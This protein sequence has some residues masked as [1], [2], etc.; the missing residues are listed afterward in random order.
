MSRE[1]KEYAKALFELSLSKKEKEERLE[2]LKKTALIM[3]GNIEKFFAHPKISKEKKKEIIK[4]D[5]P[6]GVFRNFLFVLSDNGR[7]D[8]IEDIKIDFE[9]LLLETNKAV[10]AKVFSK[11][12]LSKDYLSS[13]KTKLEKKLSKDVDLTNEIDDA[14][15]GG[16]RIEYD[17]KILDATI[18]SQ[19]SDLVAK[20]K[21]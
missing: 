8:M 18:N 19:F 10:K 12:P 1:S 4:N 13:L 17:S 6:D 9:N 2:D 5:F 16:I 15:L 7:M 14:I 11:E 20:L 21:E 3:K